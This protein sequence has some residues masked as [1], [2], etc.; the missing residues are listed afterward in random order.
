MT[1]SKSAAAE[2]FELTNELLADLELDRISLSSA[3]MKAARL[4]RL[5]SDAVHLKV[6]E[7]ELSGYPYSPDGVPTDVWQLC[8]AAGRVYEEEQG[9]AEAKKIVERANTDSIDRM[10][11]SVETAQLQLEFSRP[12]PVSVSSANP[13]QFVSAPVRN[14][15]TEN[16]AA[17][18]FR[19]AKAKLASRRSFIYSFVLA[20]HFELRVSSAAEDIFDAYRTNVDE[21]LGRIVPNELRT[22]D[23]ITDNIRSDNPEDWANAAHSC[24]RLLQGLADEIYP[25]QEGK[26]KSKSGKEIKAGE[27]NY[28]NRL[29]LFCEDKMASNTSQEILS[30]DLK[31]IGERLDSVFSGV[32]KGSHSDIEKSE[33]QRFVIH[34][35]LA[36]GDI[37]QLSDEQSNSKS[38]N[39]SHEAQSSV[40]GDVKE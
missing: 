29:V 15:Q 10:E 18:G 13:N 27:G 19:N 17:T 30:A 16:N 11:A 1:G 40:V 21:L 36:V 8:V 25:P 6:F 23:S 31:F 32:Q 3:A 33:A 9:E 39:A 7:Y 37:L 38:E 20:K 5:T 28:I 26:V 24:R 2:A 34:T 12:Q 14:L 35:Y 4:A 22:L